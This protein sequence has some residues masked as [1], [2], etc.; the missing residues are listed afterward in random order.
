MSEIPPAS[1]IAL[2]LVVVGAL[3]LLR[4][5]L[6]VRRLRAA[7]GQEGVPLLAAARAA[8]R[9]Q[10]FG[11]D[12]EPERRHAMRQFIAGLVFGLFGLLLS[13]WLLVA[14]VLGPFFSR[15]FGSS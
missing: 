2:A 4:F 8:T 11:A 9:P 5:L 7:S 10:A 15:G 14:S 6:A 1:D 12:R 13:S 3:F